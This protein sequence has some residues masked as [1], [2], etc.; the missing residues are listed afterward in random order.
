MGSILV[1]FH[2]NRAGIVHKYMNHGRYVPIQ[3]CF[4]SNSTNFIR[5]YSTIP[6]SEVNNVKY[7]EDAFSMKEQ[8]KNDNKDKSGIYI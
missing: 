3:K 6:S 7:Y 5:L 2:S 1:S 4:K 8:I